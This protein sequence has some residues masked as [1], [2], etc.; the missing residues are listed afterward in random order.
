ME[1]VEGQDLLISKDAPIPEATV[2]DYAGQIADALEAAHDKVI[3]HRDL[4]AANIKVTPQGT[5]KVL[6]FGLAKIADPVTSASSK[7]NSPTLTMRATEAGIIMGTAA[8]MAPEQALGV[9]RG[10]LGNARRTPDVRW[11]DR[12]RRACGGPQE[13]A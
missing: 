7:A 1:L 11:R 13:R 2:L 9:W 8:Y 10:A 12:V 3:V 4:K 6:D 5:I